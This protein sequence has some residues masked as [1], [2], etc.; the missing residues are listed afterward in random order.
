MARAVQYV[1]VVLQYLEMQTEEMKKENGNGN[2]EGRGEGEGEG[3][4]GRE[5]GILEDNQEQDI[6]RRYTWEKEKIKKK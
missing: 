4:E 6:G 3:E 1:E 5:G 2:E